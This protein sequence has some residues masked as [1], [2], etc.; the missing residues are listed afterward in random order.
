M[1][2]E[3]EGEQLWQELAAHWSTLMAFIDAAVVKGERLLIHC[4][5]GVSTSLVRVPT[6][7]DAKRSP[8]SWHDRARGDLILVPCRPLG[9]VRGLQL[10]QARHTSGRHTGS[11]P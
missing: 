3:K 10:T 2:D 5:D 1:D 6:G 7:S 9:G 8:K 11:S 4:D